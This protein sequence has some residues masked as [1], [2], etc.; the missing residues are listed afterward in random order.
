MATP[1]GAPTTDEGPRS[2]ACLGVVDQSDGDGHQPIGSSV[3]GRLE[4]DP[5]RPRL[6]RLQR[7]LVV[8]DAFGEHGHHPALLSSAWLMAKADTL[9][10]PASASIVRYTG[11]TPAKLQERPQRRDLEERRLAEEARVAAQRRHQEQAVDQSVGV[12]GHQ[13]DWSRG[14]QTVAPFDLNAAEEN[15]DQ[16][17]PAPTRSL[18]SQQTA[19]SAGWC[20]RTGLPRRPRSPTRVTAVFVA[21]RFLD[22]GLVWCRGT[23]GPVLGSGG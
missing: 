19:A 21:S 10:S 11:M 3:V 1:T 22:V 7:Q 5:G 23:Q 12:V 9:W 4:G 16:E 2:E 18:T 15:P 20:D 6:E 17:G 14:R 8:A 13:D